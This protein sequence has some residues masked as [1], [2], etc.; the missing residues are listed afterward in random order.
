MNDKTTYDIN[1]MTVYK[2]YDIGNILWPGHSFGQRDG[3]FEHAIERFLGYMVYMKNLKIH[4]NSIF[5]KTN[6]AEIVSN[7]P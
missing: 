2:R 7:E 6:I 4:D 1:W 3:M 5:E